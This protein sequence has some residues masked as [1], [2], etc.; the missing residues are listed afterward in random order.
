MLELIKLTMTP[1]KCGYTII[2]AAF[3]QGNVVHEVYNR[4][5]QKEN[6]F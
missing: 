4:N 3:N 2:S 1:P 6:N 5:I